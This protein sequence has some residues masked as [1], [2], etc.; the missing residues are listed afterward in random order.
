VDVIKEKI[1]YYKEY[2]RGLIIFDIALVSGI[3]TNIYQIFVKTKPFYS[4]IFSFIGLIIFILN[5]LKKCHSEQSK[6]SR[7][8]I[9]RSLFDLR[10]TKRVNFSESSYYL[11]FCFINYI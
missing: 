3:T 7:I 4:I 6:E 10:M 8:K 2:L 11:C 1:G 5:L 9:L